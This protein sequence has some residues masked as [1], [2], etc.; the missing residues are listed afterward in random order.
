MPVV[1]VCAHDVHHLGENLLLREQ[2]QDHWVCLQVC[3]PAKDS[4]PDVHL[5]RIRTTL[6]ELC[7]CAVEQV[8]QV[9]ALGVRDGV[10]HDEELRKP[11]SAQLDTH[12]TWR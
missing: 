3:V 6:L 11:A 1:D 9:C 4:F 10:L 8:A 7:V 12:N 2:A 5:R